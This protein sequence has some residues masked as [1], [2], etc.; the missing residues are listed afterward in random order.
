MTVINDMLV[1]V[2]AQ[3]EQTTLGTIAIDQIPNRAVVIPDTPSGVLPI[4]G[5]PCIDM[6]AQAT[7]VTYD[8]DTKQSKCYIPYND[9]DYLTPIIYLANETLDN[10][11]DAGWYV[12][13]EETGT[14]AN[15]NYFVVYN[16]DLSVVKDRVIVGYKYALEIELPTIYYRPEENITDYTAAL[17]VGR[18]KFACGL[19]GSFGFKIK[20]RGREEWEDV[21]ANSRA[22]Y[23][24]ADTTPIVGSEVFVIPINQRSTNYS[25]KLYSDTPY[26]V[27]LNSM[28]WEGNYSPRFY[29]RK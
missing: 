17:T 12:E 7:D 16:E 24:L 19:N 3:A 22:D 29:R 25:M 28:T 18:V 6:F 10:P 15:G 1:F 27:S 13:P 26:P 9:I 14:D 23:Y 11:I 8:P 4:I 2:T 20:S 5:N 21:I